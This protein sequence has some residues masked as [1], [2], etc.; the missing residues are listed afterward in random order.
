MEQRLCELLGELFGYK[1]V[2]MR[3]FHVLKQPNFDKP[4]SRYHTYQTARV[5][6][7]K[8]QLFHVFLKWCDLDKTHDASFKQAMRDK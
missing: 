7:S 3:L 6:M 2:G 8:V 4:L 1:D 5:E